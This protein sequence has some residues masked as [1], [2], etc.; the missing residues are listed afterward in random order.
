MPATR[1]LALKLKVSYYTIRR[2][3]VSLN[4]TLNRWMNPGPAALPQR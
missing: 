4:A 3:T 1:C 2:M